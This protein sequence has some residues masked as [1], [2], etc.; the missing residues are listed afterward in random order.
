[1]VW[2]HKLHLSPS[3]P[4]LISGPCFNIFGV[5]VER[6]GALCVVTM[7]YVFF[8]MDL[9]FLSNPLKAS[10]VCKDGPADSFLDGDEK[11]Q[12]VLYRSSPVLL[13][14]ELLAVWNPDE[15]CLVESF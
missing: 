9:F 12:L 3:S 10:S 11:E 7:D 14:P 8:C 13:E 15:K 5:Q 2:P 1:M 6:C 4:R